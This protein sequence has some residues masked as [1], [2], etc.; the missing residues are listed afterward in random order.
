MG[1]FC[2]YSTVIPYPVLFFILVLFFISLPLQFGKLLLI[3]LPIPG[4][5]PWAYLVEDKSSRDIIYIRQP[6]FPLDFS[7]FYHLFLQGSLSLVAFVLIL[8]NNQLCHILVWL[9]CLIC[10]FRLFWGS[11]LAAFGDTPSSQ[12]RGCSWWCWGEYGIDYGV[13]TIGF[14]CIYMWPWPETWGEGVWTMLSYHLREAQRQDF[15]LGK[16]ILDRV[17]TRPLCMEENDDKGDTH[18]EQDGDHTCGLKESWT[19][20]KGRRPM[21]SNCAIN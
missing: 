1:Y 10:P 18:M 20:G 14:S 11:H 3:F 5:F 8:S 15:R 2:N 16:C 4:F 21:Y 17:K 6:P 19:F 7:S 12:L 13:Q 9:C